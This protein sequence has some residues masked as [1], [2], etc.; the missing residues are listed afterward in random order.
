MINYYYSD[1]SRSYKKLANFKAGSWVHATNPT[2]DDKIKLVKNLGLADDLVHDALDVDE[3]PRLQTEEGTTYVFGRFARKGGDGRVTTVPILLAVGANF[4][5]TVS[6]EPCVE[7]EQFAKKGH[8]FETTDRARMMLEVF[9]IILETYNTQLNTINRKIRSARSSLSIAKVSNKDFIQFV[10]IEDILNEM[11]GDLVPT[12]VVL[13]TLSNPRKNLRFYDDDKEQIEDIIL[14]AGQLIDSIKGSLKTIVNIREAYS[15]IA[16]N[17]LNRQIKL[18]TTLTVV[19]TIP[20]IVGS[21][22]GMNV[23]VPFQNN[24]LAFLGIIAATS[25]IA[26]LI[27]YLF[28]KSG[29]L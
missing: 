8:E 2:E 22:F 28:R 13:Q 1:K 10:E 21:F 15:N 3:M 25:G 29:W 19:L 12:N 23:P 17:N 7:V 14:T 18:L 11:L 4:F 9:E 26:A 27:I 20:T 16:T 24:S 6:P 5:A